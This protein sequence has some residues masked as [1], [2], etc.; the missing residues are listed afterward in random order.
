MHLFLM[1]AQE[2]S[3]NSRKLGGGIMF[4]V[5]FKHV[6]I[7]DLQDPTSVHKTVLKEGDTTRE[8]TLIIAGTLQIPWY[9]VEIW[10]PRSRAPSAADDEI[11]SKVAEGETISFRK[12][13]V[14]MELGVA[15][16]GATSAPSTAAP[17]TGATSAFQAA[18]STGA[19]SASSGAA[20]STAGDTSAP[21][22]A[23]PS[24]GATSAFQ[25]APSTGATSAHPAALSTGA[26]SAP[27]QAAPSTEATSAHPAAPSAAS[28]V[29]SSAP[30]EEPIEATLA[31]LMEQS[32]QC[33]QSVLINPELDNLAQACVP[34]SD[35]KLMCVVVLTKIVLHVYTYIYVYACMLAHTHLCTYIYIAERELVM[36]IIYTCMHC[37]YTVFC[38]VGVSA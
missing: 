31:T 1:Q 3:L 16:S 9:Q 24:T 11:Y 17:S 6:K 13:T 35:L 27:L 10:L 22:T 8:L 12:T 37:I 23:A 21:S 5:P 2:H 34:L 4:L 30:L 7:M 33:S 25:A 38:F 18:P 19:T 26:T 36:F 14:K 28:T 29:A 20:P 32:S 15:P